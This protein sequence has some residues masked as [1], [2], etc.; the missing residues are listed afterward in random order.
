MWAEFEEHFVALLSPLFP[1]Y[2]DI[3]RIQPDSEL[4]LLVDWKLAGVPDRPNKRSRKLAIHICQETLEDYSAAS[5][6]HRQLADSRLVQHV[7]QL[8]NAFNPEHDTPYGMPE[9]REEW[10]I[11][12]SVINV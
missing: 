6:Q 7:S 11:Q 3:R 12:S 1:E 4:C 8:L 9:P 5:T 10:V 2:A